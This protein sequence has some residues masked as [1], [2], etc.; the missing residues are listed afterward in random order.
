MGQKQKLGD[1]A[2]F[3]YPYETSGG[4]QGTVIFSH[5]GMTVRTYTVIEMA[6]GMLASGYPQLLG[7]PLDVEVVASEALRQADALLAEL[8]KPN[9]EAQN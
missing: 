6:K 8:E 5:T 3:P 7:P 9:A 4:A 2:A 1:V